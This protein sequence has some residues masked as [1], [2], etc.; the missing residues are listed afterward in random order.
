VLQFTINVPQNP[1][2]NLSA[3]VRISPV[4]R[5]SPSA[6][7]FMLPAASKMLAS[8]SSGVSIFILLNLFYFFTDLIH[9]IFFLHLQSLVVF[10]YMFRTDCSIIRRIKFFIT[11]AASGTVP[12]VVDL[13]CVAVSVRL[14]SNTN[15]H[16]R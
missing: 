15:G 2:V 14:Q 4:V 7:F 1:N 13:S 11:Q 6:R 5:L 3:L 8:S 10:L 16:A 9:L 12:S